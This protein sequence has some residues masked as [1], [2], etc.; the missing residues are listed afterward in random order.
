MA[1]EPNGSYMLRGLGKCC[2]RKFATGFLQDSAIVTLQLGWDLSWALRMSES[3][4]AET[5]L[6]PDHHTELERLRVGQLRVICSVWLAQGLVSTLRDVQ[7]LCWRCKPSTPDIRNAIRSFSV[8]RLAGPADALVGMAHPSFQWF[9]YQA[10]WTGIYARSCGE[11]RPRFR[12]IGFAHLYLYFD[13]PMHDEAVCP[14][15]FGVCVFLCFHFPCLAWMMRLQS[16]RP[17][18]H[19]LRTS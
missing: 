11:R 8:Q 14:G 10:V 3:S 17:R 4:Q 13:D 18:Q 7:D 15:R 16:K 2:S 6:N 5:F 9:L 19:T 12:L 1:D